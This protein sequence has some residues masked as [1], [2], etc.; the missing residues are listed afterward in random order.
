[1]KKM[2]IIRNY[3][4]I[5]CKWFLESYS[6]PKNW[7]SWTYTIEQPQMNQTELNTDINFALVAVYYLD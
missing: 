1:M 5:S 4:I 7:S 2:Q 3:D 6:G